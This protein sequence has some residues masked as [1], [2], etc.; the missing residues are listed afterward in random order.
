MNGSLQH[1][2]EGLYREKKPVGVAV[3]TD[4][5][6]G[7]PGAYDLPAPSKAGV[8]AASPVTKDKDGKPVINGALT[9]D[10]RDRWV[11]RTGWAPRFGNGDPKDDEGPSLLDHETWLEGKI[12]DKFFGGKHDSSSAIRQSLTPLLQIGITTRR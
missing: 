8:V 9:H 4:L 5:D 10:E 11:E 1:A 3:A 12:E 6:D 2:P 7:K